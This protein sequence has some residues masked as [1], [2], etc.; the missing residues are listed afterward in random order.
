M[1]EAAEVA[2]ELRE[3]TLLNL[4]L[5][6]SWGVEVEARENFRGAGLARKLLV[7]DTRLGIADARQEG[8]GEHWLES[9]LDLEQ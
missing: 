3:E 7:S 2:V 8:A 9:T 5:W 6:W 1:V 4:L